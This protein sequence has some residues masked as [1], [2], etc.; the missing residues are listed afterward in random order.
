MQ[1]GAMLLTMFIAVLGMVSCNTPKKESGSMA[2]LEAKIKRYVPVT[3]TGDTARLSQGDRLA[4]GKLIEATRYIDSIFLRQVWHGNPAL[5][6]QLEADTSPEGKLR[7]DLFRIEC[8]PWSSLDHQDPFVAGVPNP[9]PD[10]ANYYP[11]DMTKEEFTLVGRRTF[12]VRSQAGRGLLSHHT[13]HSGRKADRRPV[14]RR[15]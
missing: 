4:L 15:V 9:R 3:L 13:P 12:R 1:K 6:K 14:Q 10:R 7:L 8:G 2:E 5:L 11:D